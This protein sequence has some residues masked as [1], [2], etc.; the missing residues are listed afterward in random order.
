MMKQNYERANVT[1]FAFG[2]KDV[3]T[4]SGEVVSPGTGGA[5]VMPE[6]EV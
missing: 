2:A 4:T 6:D 3:I 5:V 1:V